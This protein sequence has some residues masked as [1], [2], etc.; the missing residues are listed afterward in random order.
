MRAVCEPDPDLDWETRH[1][2][3]MNA[4]ISLWRGRRGPWAE[5]G[6]SA[7]EYDEDDVVE[8]EDNDEGP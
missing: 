6:P 3:E 5:W 4:V 8:D 7:E 1:V 2:E